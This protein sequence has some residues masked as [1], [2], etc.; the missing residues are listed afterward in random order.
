MPATVPSSAQPGPAQ[1]HTQPNSQQQIRRHNLTRVL[2]AVAVHEGT[3]SRASVATHIGLTRA[4][5]STLVD[6]LLRAELLVELGPGR[7]GGV[8]RPGS[9]LA[10]T[11]RGPCGIGAEIG[12]D[13]LT[14]C[15]V[16]LSGRVRVRA[17][18]CSDNRGSDPRAVLRR[19]SELLW[20]AAEQ[21]EEAGL[22][23]AGVAIAVPGLV[24]RGSGTV[25][26][27][28]NLGWPAV[29]PATE[30]TVPLPVTLDNE[31]NYGALAELWL[32]HSQVPSD[33][34]HVSAE[35]GIGGAVVL[36]GRLLRGV[37]GFAGELGHVPV[38]PSGRECPCGGRGC[39]EQYA[40]EGALL[41]GA[42]LPYP[43]DD[44]PIALLAERAAEGHRTTRRALREAGTALGI[45]L[46]GAVNLLDPGAV[47]LGGAL[48]RLGSWLLPPLEAELAAR[49]TAPEGPPQVLL[50][51]AGDDG[52]VL[53]AAH[54]VVRVVRADPLAYAPATLSSLPARR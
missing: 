45:A 40:G 31:A 23:A 22:R 5:V 35:I 25:V 4:A 41:R 44:D 36:D 14:V 2:N 51:S 46:S 24:D 38:R 11:A 52:P 19:L 54:S 29:A 13:R 50:S 7:P 43:S 28:P 34:V 49:C 1:P 37:R 47:S 17:E 39:L 12:V 3:A 10:L 48:A 32:G 15:A 6:E 16:D 30:L 20:E 42:G 9:A 53:G 33:F 8:G 27:A 21:A 18:Q 26:R